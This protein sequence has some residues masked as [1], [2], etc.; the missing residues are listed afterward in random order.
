MVSL[1]PYFVMLTIV[2]VLF[3][4]LGRLDPSGLLRWGFGAGFLLCLGHLV[5]A[6]RVNA[7]LRRRQLGRCMACGYSLIGNTSGVCP[8]CGNVMH[9]KP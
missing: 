9:R 3:Y 1:T 5:Q 6:L 4:A 8:E 7:I 2:A